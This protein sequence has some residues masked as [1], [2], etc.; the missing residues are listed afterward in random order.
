MAQLQALRRRIRSI[1]NTRQTTRAMQLVDATKLRRAQE[2]TG[3]SKEYINATL[4]TLRELLSEDVEASELALWHRPEVKSVGL[5]VIASD[6]GLAGAYNLNIASRLKKEVAEYRGQGVKVKIVAIGVH[7]IRVA[8]K[9]DGAEVIDRI[10]GR[11][12]DPEIVDIRPLARTLRSQ[13]ETGNI[14]Q[15][16]VIYTHS[17]SA[18]KQEVRTTSIWPVEVETLEAASEAS[19]AGN[20]AVTLLEPSAEEVVAA[21][22]ARLFDASVLHAAQEAGVSEHA[23]RMM[24]MRNATDNASDLIDSLTLQVNTIRQAGI[25]QEISEITGAAAAIE[26]Q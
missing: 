17:V 6:R 8:E 4:D 14:D 10:T 7:A 21:A 15:I 13:Y 20:K 5:V 19:P 25:T 16:R 23:M 24:A 3:R 12:T 2:A 1:S 11:Q 9:L 22:L 26:E 18:L